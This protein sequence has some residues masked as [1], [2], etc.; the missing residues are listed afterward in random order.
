MI[1]LKIGIETKLIENPTQTYPI[2]FSI[3]LAAA[4][5]EIGL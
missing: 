4:V 2:L 5:K 1:P 3:V